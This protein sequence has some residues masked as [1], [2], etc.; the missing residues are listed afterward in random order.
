[1]WNQNSNLKDKNGKEIHDGD[2]I[3]YGD[4][5]RWAKLNARVCFVEGCFGV[6]E[7]LVIDGEKTNTSRIQTLM[8]VVE[9]NPTEIIGNIYESKHL[10]DNINTKV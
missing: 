10:L 1:M 6:I 7:T 8:W 2:V 5:Q 3:Q 9:N 4:N